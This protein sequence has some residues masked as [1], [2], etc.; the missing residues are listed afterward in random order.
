[1]PDGALAMSSRSPG[2][3]DRASGPDGHLRQIVSPIGQKRGNY[4]H[5]HRR[6]AAAKA[7]SIIG[8]IVIGLIAGFIA[9]KIVNKTAQALFSTSFPV[10][11]EQLLGV[12]RWRSSA[13]QA[14][15]IQYPQHACCSRGRDHCV[16]DLPPGERPQRRVKASCI[17][18][19]LAFRVRASVS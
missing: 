15:R 3:I 2:Q 12:L 1:M 19:E 14:L 18:A 8:C 11:W 17:H 9:S 13:P 5:H 10:S 7:M 16:G 4:A 6:T